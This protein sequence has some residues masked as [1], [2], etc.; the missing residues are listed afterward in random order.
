V[1]YQL[2]PEYQVPI[3]DGIRA[4]FK[5]GNMAPM[6]VCP[7]RGGKTVIFSHMAEVASNRDNRVLI[8]AHNKEL[9]TQC[10]EKMV[11]NGV[12]F[13]YINPGF[14]PDYRKKIQVGTIQSIVSRMESMYYYRRPTSTT[15]NSQFDYRS[16]TQAA[17]PMEDREL[18]V[19]D[20]IIIDEAHRSLAPTY[21]KIIEY[22]RMFN[23]NLRII[24]F[25]ATPVRGDKKALNSLYDDL[26]MGPQVRFLINLGVLVE[27]RTFGT[28]IKIDTEGLT[29]QA[30]GDY[31]L[32]ELAPRVDT[33]IITGDAVKHYR[34][35]CPGK[36]AVVYCVSV[37]HSK[38]VAVEF[39]AAGF[40][41][42]H[43]DG[44]MTDA[45]KTGILTRLRTGVINGITSVNLVTEG[46]DAP[47][48]QCVILLRPT[49]SLSLAIQMAVR[50]MGKHKGKDCCYILDHANI[51][52]T[53]AQ[54]EEPLG[55]V[56]DDRSWSLNGEE[57]KKKKKKK[58]AGEEKEEKTRQCPLCFRLHK[59]SPTCLH[60][61]YVYEI[62]SR[63]VDVVP[64]E[65]VEIT[66]KRSLQ[67][68]DVDQ[69]KNIAEANGLPADWAKQI[70]QE[71]ELR[72]V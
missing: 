54:G 68:E 10:G 64:G 4:S 59:P 20:L 26:V 40:L 63:Y 29:I 33:S 72:E 42:E 48:L 7:A 51:S 65:L 36:S 23:E 60:C 27:P 38:N 53:L 16:P 6:V 66:K 58:K 44:T 34:D 28:D 13:G 2:Y 9:C 52:A 50:A 69:L 32:S 43:I 56:D 39:N 31:D 62:K 45:E 12:D 18:W 47:I 30:N 71:W 67:Q 35:I 22:Y 3:V 70:Q 25:T 21:I 5:K 46:F 15:G 57:L 41:F 61:D 8:M 11:A 19:P 24:G 55:F 37:E 49:P 17:L 1:K 14:K